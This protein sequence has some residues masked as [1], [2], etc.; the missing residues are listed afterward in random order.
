MHLNM[1]RTRE[2]VTQIFSAFKDG[3][4]YKILL[5]F[6]T[7][8]KKLYILE[9]WKDKHWCGHTDRQT[10]RQFNCYI[11][12]IYLQENL[13]VGCSH[14]FIYSIMCKKINIGF[15]FYICLIC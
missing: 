12:N 7:I 8:M 5:E 10:D 13:K 14:V 2:K 3:C 1:A 11:T 15:T 9:M 4:A 6:N